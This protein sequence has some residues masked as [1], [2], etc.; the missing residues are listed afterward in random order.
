MV[1]QAGCVAEPIILACPSSYL[2]GGDKHGVLGDAH[3]Q[4]MVAALR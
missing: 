4:P 2:V 3:R 1:Q